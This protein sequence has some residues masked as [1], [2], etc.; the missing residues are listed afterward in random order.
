MQEEPWL[1][2]SL[3]ATPVEAR[4]RTRRRRRRSRAADHNGVS[5]SEPPPRHLA[6]VSRR[7]A[8]RPFWRRLRELKQS[9]LA[10]RATNS[11]ARYSPPVRARPRLPEQ[12]RRRVLIL[13]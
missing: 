4:S 10:A 12:D 13:V 9:Q 2:R 11:A 1:L 3:Q 6:Q 8:P 7:L 5:Q